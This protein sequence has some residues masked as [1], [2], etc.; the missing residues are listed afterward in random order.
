M[1]D[2]DKDLDEDPALEERSRNLAKSKKIR[3]KLLDL[4]KDV[5]KGF[6]DQ[7]TRADDQADYWDI[8]NN[9]TGQNQFYTGNSRIFV[10][11]T[12]NAINARKTRFINQIFPT[13][14]RCVEVTSEDGT[15][16]HTMV[17]LAEHYVTKAKLRQ[18]MPAI[19]RN[20]DVEGQFNLY[21]DWSSRKRHVV[22]RVKKPVDLGEGMQ[23]PEG[24][25]VDDI[26]E[27]VLSSD[28]PYVEILADSDVCILPATAQSLEQAI[29]DGG[30]ATIL[31]RW[32]KA[33]IKKLIADGEIEEK[34][35]KV[36]ME[37]MNSE[38]RE[39]VPNKNKAMAQAAGV[40]GEGSGKYVLVYE[41]WSMIK[42]GSGE[43]AEI[44][45]C[46]SYL[47][48]PD[49]VLSCVRNPNWSD[50]CPLISEPLEKV[51]GS[52][53]GISK[54]AAV[55]DL[56]YYA[57]DVINEAADSS[58]FSLLPIILTDPL[59]NPKVG[60]MVLNLAAVWETS[61]NDTKFAQFP[62]LWKQGLEIIANVQQTIFQTLSVN[63]SQITQGTKKKQSQ[64]EVAQEQQVDV[65]TTADVVTVVEDRVLTQLLERFIELDHQHRDQPIRIREYGEIGIKQSMAEVDPIQLGT[66]YSIRWFGVEQVRSAQQIQQQIGMINVIKTIPPQQ[67]QGYRLNLAPAISAM[68]EAGFGP[69]LAPLIFEDMRSQLSVDPKQE[70]AL[71]QMGHDVPVHELDDH[72]A[73]IQDH[74]EFGKQA[75][76]PHGLIRRHVLEHV[77]KLEQAA[78]AQAQVAKPQPGMAGGG[79]GPRP[80]AQPAQ[81][82]PAQQ[83]PG[84]VS[85]DQTPTAMPR[86][87]MMG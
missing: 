21:V 40:K 36:L 71:L 60:S 28:H 69:R 19:M 45:L 50:R 22:R 38:A 77:Q 42:I 81:Q 46:R 53:K 48:G 62:E 73:H 2:E 68:M 67:Y 79:G 84:A 72:K 6:Q 25:D 3:D 17:A 39:G 70:D 34:L 49:K 32:G 80:G 15:I 18:L 11:I 52:V 61:P 20:G 82:R 12:Y 78:Q 8:Y 23:G 57:N 43:D 54:V 87:R 66:R 7:R 26:E 5:E 29:A 9:I 14:G 83:P 30:S 86:G 24:E 1:A 63:P 44:R 35:G 55:A 64:A 16:P 56:Q 10:P 27:E 51:Q 59:K 37:E 76:D 4:Y 65:L 31:R 85:P 47:G 41:T 58:L 74:I 33:K 13:S 75:G